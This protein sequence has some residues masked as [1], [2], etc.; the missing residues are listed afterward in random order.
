MASAR[1]EL[2]SDTRLAAMSSFLLGHITEAQKHADIVISQFDRA[3]HGHVMITYGQDP[4]TIA[5]A[6]V[7][8]YQ[9]VTG[10]PEKACRAWERAI[11]EALELDHVGT[12]GPVLAWGGVHGHA[13]K[14]DKEGMRQIHEHL[15]VLT[16]HHKMPIW[17][18]NERLA[19]AML[20]SMDSPSEQS[21]AELLDVLTD[22]EAFT[23]Y[24]SMLFP[25]EWGWYLAENYCAIGAPDLALEANEKGLKFAEASKEHWSDSELF[26]MRGVALA[27]RDGVEGRRF[28]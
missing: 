26:R 20:S 10:W 13:L 12:L 28:I 17:E 6:Y 3:R 9:W 11:E 4:K 25:L 7:S 8:V 16:S 19:K 18:I 24:P 15:R 23:V 27:M 5:E 21:V 14:R 22:F 2:R 1:R